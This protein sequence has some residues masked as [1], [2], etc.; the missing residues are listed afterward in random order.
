MNGVSALS[1]TSG[2]SRQT[3]DSDAFGRSAPGSSPASVRIWKP[4]QMPRTS[5]PSAAKAA[6]AR[7]IG[8]NRAIAPHR[9]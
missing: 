2:T 6:T 7:M 4:L 9:R 8:E 1:T 3:N 5:P